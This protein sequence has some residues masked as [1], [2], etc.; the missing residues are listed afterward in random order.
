MIFGMPIGSRRMP[1]VASEVPPEPPAEMTPPMS[2]WRTIQRSNAVAIASTALP[3]IAGKDARSRRADGALATS[4]GVTSV[5][6]G[7][8]DV[9]RST[10]RVRMPRSRRGRG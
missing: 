9:E 6:D 4:C 3:A 1:A 8:P 10:V 5:L 2:R 7:L